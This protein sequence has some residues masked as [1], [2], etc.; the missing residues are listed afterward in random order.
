MHKKTKKQI[1]QFIKK[2]K[3]VHG[4]KPLYTMQEMM[5]VYEM[6]KD[7]YPSTQTLFYKSK[8]NVGHNQFSLTGRKPRIKRAEPSLPEEIRKDP[9]KLFEYLFS[10]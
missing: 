3:E 4:E 2:M 5:Q 9:V 8:F 10:D 7:N 6:D 1:R